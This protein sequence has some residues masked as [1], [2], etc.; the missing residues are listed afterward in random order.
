MECNETSVQETLDTLRTSLHGLSAFEIETRLK[1]YG[2][3]EIR[4]SKKVSVLSIFFKQF[5]SMVIYILIAAIIISLI[6]TVEN[7]KK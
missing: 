3:N 1:K 7:S 5:K 4:K 6:F 2:L